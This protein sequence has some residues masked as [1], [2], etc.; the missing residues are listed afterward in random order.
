M[1]QPTAK[2]PF[3]KVWSS[4][5]DQ[6][7]RSSELFVE[8]FRATYAEYPDLP[9]WVA[10]EVMSFGCLSKMLDGMLKADQKSVSARY[11]AQ[12][13]TLVSWAHHLVYVRN[14]CAHHARLWDK[15]WTVKPHLPAGKHWRP[16]RL[17]DNKR[18][19][20]TLVLLSFLMRQVSPLRSFAADWRVRI[21][22][23]VADP[24]RVINALQKMGLDAAWSEHF[25][26]Q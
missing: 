11:A 19:F 8:H 3:P 17:T 15:V 5:S 6:A 4:C 10:T 20:S 25:Y 26:W 14:L 2:A 7:R 12:P 1:S 21:A 9:V 18:L 13:Q 24:P 23:R 16:P 22:A